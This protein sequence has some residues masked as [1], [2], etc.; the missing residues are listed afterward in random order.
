MCIFVL[1][2]GPRTNPTKK[3]FVTMRGMTVNVKGLDSRG[4]KRQNGNESLPYRFCF[5]L[6]KLNTR[7]TVGTGFGHICRK[8]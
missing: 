1:C 2:K 6:N 8:V 3:Y 7:H 4:G 5:T